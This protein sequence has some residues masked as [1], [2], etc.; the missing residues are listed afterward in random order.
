MRMPPIGLL[1]CP[2]CGAE[3]NETAVALVCAGCRSTYT[4][5][6]GIPDLRLDARTGSENDRTGPIERA[7]Q[8]LVASPAV[9]DAVQRLAGAEK[10]HRQLRAVLAVAEGAL[11][12]DV[13]GGTGGLETLLPSSARYLWLDTDPQKLMG[14]IAKSKSPAL[15]GDATRI[16][17]KDG[18]VDWSV[19]VG[20]S[21]HLDDEDLL[22]TLRELRRVTR[23]R[24]LFLDAVAA[25]AIRSRLLWH[26]DRGRYP[27]AAAVLKRE[28]ESQLDIH[29]QKE[30]T[31]HHRY[32]LVTAS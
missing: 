16:P 11:V 10:L 8:A 30:F 29:S 15:L 17:L 13:G 9:Y 22:R 32:L 14:F 26:Y 12:L 1:A 28:L 7:L 21:H 24:I 25:P 2:S 23:N 3:L 27:R 19:S 31:V 4:M 20:V 6:E 5:R 18:S